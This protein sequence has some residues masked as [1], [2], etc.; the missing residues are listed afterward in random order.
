[1]FS[2]YP[3]STFDITVI[4]LMALMVLFYIPT[5]ITKIWECVPRAK[6]WDKSIPGHCIDAY[7]LLNVSGIFNTVTDFIIVLLPLGRVWTLKMQL[8]KKVYVVFAFTFGMCAPVFSFVGS[9]VRLRSTNNPDKT[10]VQPEIV[11]WGL[12]ELTTG[13]LCV[14]FPELGVLLRGQ[15]R[16]P[17]IEAST[18]V[19]EGQYRQQDAGFHNLRP[20]L[21]IR[22][23]NVGTTAST[24]HRAGGWGGTMTADSA[25]EGGGSRLHQ[26][27]ELE[28]V[29][30]I[31]RLA[32]AVTV[33]S[34]IMQQH[35]G[36]FLGDIEVTREVKM[37]SNT[38]V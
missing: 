1:M 27:V 17:G 32:A 37:D 11:M 18:G 16:R 35:S 22:T 10:W 31:H 9:I 2:V 36:M 38:T 34:R 33:K 23:P 12:A 6:I 4:A 8:K 13:I 26:Y 15:V 21:F 3:R 25:R 30:F 19:R 14:S 29:N 20:R 24:L 28:G 7:V 5:T